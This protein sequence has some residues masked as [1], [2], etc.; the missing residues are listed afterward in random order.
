M[1]MEDIFII[2]NKGLAH[3]IYEKEGKLYLD[4][5]KIGIIDKEG[6]RNLYK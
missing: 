5:N 6:K 1:L 4:G 3:V 2:D